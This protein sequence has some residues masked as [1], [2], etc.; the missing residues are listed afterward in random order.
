MNKLLILV[1]VILNLFTQTVSSKEIRSMFGFYLDLPR[2]YEPVQNLNL[3][4]LLKD[5]P[6]MDINKEL[7]DEVMT[8]SAKGDLDIEYFF[9]IKYNFEF[10]NLYI[11]HARGSIKEFMIMDFKD[12]C[13]GLK[14]LYEGLWKKKNIK[15]YKCI[16]NPKEIDINSPLIVKI[17]HEG[18]FR[19]TKL[20]NYFFQIDN[21]YTTTVS[22]GCEVK[23]CRALEKDL[24]NVANSIKK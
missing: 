18:P 20:F 23:N 15:Q 2:D 16:K 14:N 19:G 17:I 22:L 10:N 6:N 1:I 21:G 9:P 3:N 8:G 7:M 4:Q 13:F 5:N 24:I 12:L 11:T